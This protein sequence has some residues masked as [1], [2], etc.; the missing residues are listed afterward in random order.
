MVMNVAAVNAVA[1]DSL[2]PGPAPF[3]TVTGN[4]IRRKG[5]ISQM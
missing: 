3:L 2:G 1:L 4:I 5:G